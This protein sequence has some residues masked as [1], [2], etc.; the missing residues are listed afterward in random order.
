MKV[1]AFLIVL[2]GLFITNISFATYK[3]EFNNKYL[4]LYDNS[5]II[6]TWPAKAGGLFSTTND[7]NKKNYGP[8]PEGVYTA[9][10]SNRILFF[11]TKNFKYKIHRLI[12]YPAWGTSAL[13]LIP[14]N[15]NNMYGRSDFY[16]HGGGWIA[17]SK[18]CIYLKSSEKDFFYTLK[19]LHIKEFTLLVKYPNKQEKVVTN[20]KSK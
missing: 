20:D 19:S 8:L 9:N 18:G 2:S 6:K 13:A 7:Q 15:A 4:T 11:K 12:K 1:F 14:N 10:L 17:G 16:I 3:L 5:Q